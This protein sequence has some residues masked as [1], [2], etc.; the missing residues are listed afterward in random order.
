MRRPAR[1]IGLLSLAGLLALASLVAVVPPASAATV[2]VAFD[3]QARPPIGGPQQLTLATAVQAD[4]PAAVAAGAT[5][6]VAVAPDPMTVPGNV[7]GYTVN[8]LTGLALSFPVPE[9]STFQS[10]TLTGGSNLGRGTP[11]VS[12]SGSVVTVRI[13]GP[14]AGGATF[15][16]PVLHVTLVASGQPGTTVDTRLAGTSYDDPGL[17]FTANVRVV[18]FNVDVPTRC[19]ANPSPTFTSTAIT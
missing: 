7:A 16:L 19:Y 3:C 10:A 2:P 6:E 9:G 4:G 14:I 13:P 18:F 15:Q 11:T 5:F 8:R 17:T 12:R 1:P